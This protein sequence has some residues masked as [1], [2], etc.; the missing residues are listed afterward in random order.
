MEINKNV[1]QVKRY[2]FFFDQTKCV[3]CKT[4]TVACKMYYDVK[5]GAVSYR[6]HLTYEADNGVGGYY[7]FVQACNHCEDPACLTACGVQAISKRPDGIVEVDRNKCQNLRTCISACP[8]AQ[9]GIADD[10]QEPLSKETW[11][12]KHPMQKCNMCVELLDKGEET[13]C[14]AACPAHAIY[15]GDYDEIMRT[16]PDVEQITPGKFPY[17]YENNTNDTNPSLLVRPNNKILKISG[18]N[19]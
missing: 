9:P 18:N 7:N 11:M 6:N 10:K 1:I 3:G 14:V 5:P 16:Y 12:I 15:V 4:C 17:A 13:V 19:K 8:F 2:A